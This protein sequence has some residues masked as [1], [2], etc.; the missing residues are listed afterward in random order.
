MR[1]DHNEEARSAS[2]M[3]SDMRLGWKVTALGQPRYWLRS[4]AKPGQQDDDDLVL[5]APRDMGTHSVIVAQ[6]GSGKSFL[7]G[8]LIEELLVTTRARCVILDP[9]ADFFRVGEIDSS[10]WNAPMFEHEADIGRLPTEASIGDF[11]V[12]WDTVDKRILT[13]A[14]RARGTTGAA[15][16]YS[17]VR[18]WW[19]GLSMSHVLGDLSD[20]Q[21]LEQLENCHE[22][23][24]L[25]QTLLNIRSAVEDAAN[26]AAVSWNPPQSEWIVRLH[27]LMRFYAKWRELAMDPANRSEAVEILLSSV[28]LTDELRRLTFVSKVRDAMRESYDYFGGTIGYRMGWTDNVDI[29]NMLYNVANRA[30]N[31]T[32]YAP[33]EAMLLYLSRF[34]RF[35]TNEVIAIDAASDLVG[36]ERLTVV[37]LPALEDKTLRFLC[38]NS[39]IDALWQRARS[40]WQTA[41]NRQAH[42][43]DR[44]PTFVVIDE[45]HNLAIR[46][47]QDALELLVRERLRTIAAEGRKYGMFLILVTQRP[48]KL[49]PLILSECDNKAL[50]RLDSESILNLSQQLLGLDDVPRRQLERCL[51]FGKGRALLAGKWVNRQPTVLYSAARRT[52]EGGRSLRDDFWARP[53]PALAAAATERDD[54]TNREV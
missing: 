22:I 4:N 52:V 3:L 11:V 42:E 37:D 5:V 13:T 16:Q 17:P 14:K 49:D 18:L 7:L 8:R 41:L 24:K 23:A 31:K 54:A 29:M 30:T 27:G 28:G 47:P 21:L 35:S 46:E 12:L 2:H 51:E 32:F 45:A 1:A 38:V 6:S 53:E 44:V 43:D 50:M 19:F 15:L 20:L 34:E 33:V 48:D 10:V 39:V 36:H 26:K 25:I 40:Q 9:N